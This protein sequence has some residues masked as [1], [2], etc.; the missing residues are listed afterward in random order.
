MLVKLLRNKSILSFLGALFLILGLSLVSAILLTT[1]Y[2][3]GNPDA[4]SQS[5][6]VN[7]RL[8][9]ITVGATGINS[10]YNITQLELYAVTGI[11]GSNV[12]IIQ[13]DP[14]N[15]VTVGSAIARNTSIDTSTWSGTP[16]WH[17]ISLESITPTTPNGVYAIT[18]YGFEAYLDTAGSYPG[19]SRFSSSN[20]G[21][22][23][24]ASLTQDY[25]FYIFSNLSAFNTVTLVS[26]SDDTLFAN[27]EVFNVSYMADPSLLNATYYFWNSTNGIVNTTTFAV[28]GNT[29]STS[30]LLNSLTKAGNYHWNALACNINGCEWAPANGT[31][32]YGYQVNN[33]SYVPVVTEGTSQSYILNLTLGS[34]QSLTGGTFY[35]NVT[36]VNS[37]IDSIGQDRILTV[38]DFEVPSFTATADVDF[39]W[40]LV[41]GSGLVTNTTAETQTVNVVQLDNCTM[42]T[43]LILNLSL[44][45]ERTQNSLNGTIEILYTVLNKPFY[46]EIETL[47][48]KFVGVNGTLVC[49]EEN[50]FDSNLAYSAE[51]KYYA[52]NHSSE[53]YNIQKADLVNNT[54]GLNL[55]DLDSE[56]S[57]EFKVTYQDDTFTHVEDA[58]IQLQREYIGDGDYKIVEAPLTSN[59][60]TV[61]LHIDLDSNRYRATVVKDGEVLDTFNNLVFVCDSPLVGDCTQKL[62][63]TVDPR[64]SIPLTSLLDFSYADPVI[65]NQTITI[66]YS[67]PSN[68][69][70]SVG[71][72]LVQKDQFG[73]ETLCDQTIVSSAGSISCDF[74]ATIG[75]S[76][77]DLTLTKNG[78]II[79]QQSYII[80]EDGAFDFLGNNF[81]IVLLFML[82]LVGMALS[83]PEWIIING[84]VVFLIAGALW[85]LNGLSFVVGLG[86]L[87][88]LVV[89]AG[90]MIF[91]LTKQ[92][93][94]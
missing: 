1:E 13:W 61:V 57:T 86:S 17:N 30:L 84:V 74:I 28:T 55:Y 18:Y 63:G 50:L 66:S 2:Y 10:A 5:I 53:L 22:T 7:L 71:I 32:T 26:P 21:A 27:A 25:L 78:V 80:P 56:H 65:D 93:D 85:L 67:I 88:W 42:F 33:I 52:G 16:E 35:Y 12:T 59:E 90:I 89:A 68:S 9:T 15:N 43:N 44:K 4:S 92:E 39:F 60:G 51:I 36:A 41:F 81:F 40:E 20:G 64:N 11:A 54:E 37:S 76:Y 23:W 29:N 49:A 6:G 14:I 83:S 69:P 77:I 82:S 34:G 3:D 94:R 47:S 38:S 72:S 87:M 48:A 46:N 91:K 79:L 75:D 24:T 31:F 73:N 45:D 70:A 58:V 62:I 19:G 8:Q